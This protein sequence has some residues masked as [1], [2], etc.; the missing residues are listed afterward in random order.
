MLNP[1]DIK[2]KKFERASRGY[3]IEEVDSFLNEVAS[4]YAKILN[5]FEQNEGKI[6]KLVDKINEYRDDEDTIKSAIL[7]A[8]KQGKQTLF[9]AEQQAS[10]IIY[11]ATAKSEQLIIA[12]REEYANEL[13]KLEGLKKEIT[14]FKSKLTEL[15]NKQLRLIMDIPD[16]DDAESEV[17]DIKDDITE[18]TDSEIKSEEVVEVKN[19]QPTQIPQQ[20]PQKNN[21][22]FSKETTNSN[23]PRF[24]ELRF[25][26]KQNK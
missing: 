8:Q 24:G 25:G 2:E 26:N 14:C 17:D 5:D 21:F 4:S 16:F 15:Y 10:K 19:E 23:Q 6:I 11:D 13:S 9:E 18:D 3:N 22:P 12:T 20:E 1:K 7:T